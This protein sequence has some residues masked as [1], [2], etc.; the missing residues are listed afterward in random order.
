M[1]ETRSE[2]ERL[3]QEIARRIYIKDPAAWCEQKLGDTLWSGQKKILEAVRKYRK[4]AVQSCH[5]IGK[6][7]ISGRIVAWW[8]DI[9]P[10]GESFVVTSAPTGPQVRT[11]LW[12]EI[13]RAHTKGNLAGRVNQTEWIIRM[14]G[15]NGNPGKEEQVAIG[16]K[17]SDYD[18]AAFQGIHEKRVLYIFDEACGMPL[19]LWEAADSLIAN[20]YSRGLAFGNPD[21]PTTEFCEICKPGSG[22]HV[23][24]IGAFD[25]P[26]FTG[27]DIP[28]DLRERLIGRLY[29]EEKR[30]KWARNWT[31]V[32]K[33]GNPSDADEGVRVVPPPGVDIH[34][35]G[36]FWQSKVLG[37]F[38]IQAEED[39]L[40]PFQWVR[41]AQE[42]TLLPGSENELGIDVGGGGDAS[43]GAHRRGNV[44]RVRWQ[45]RN[46]DTMATTG[47]VVN[48][49]DE[50]SATLAKV[51]L[52]GIGKGVFDRLS[53][54]N[55]PVE[56]INVGEKPD[57][58]KRFVNRRA[59]L[60][61]HLRDLFE[62][63]TIDIDADDEDLASELISVRYKRNSNGKIQIETKIEAQKRNVPSPNRA[64]SIML[65]MA[66]PRPVVRRATWGRR[67][68]H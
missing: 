1:L 65:A 19:N 27:E 12:R 52:V 43:C 56:G 15:K 30:R 34:Q 53:E 20:D 26:N 63:G 2:L 16:R 58:E 35:T 54:L 31:W 10:A 45:D 25:T 22:W 55:R 14:P 48:A 11:I 49:L 68:T 7:F 59:E 42:R 37:E 41:A 64:E 38:P 3:E 33:D 51:D 28:Q 66:P 17:P 57:D 50:T 13:G 29:V 36:A 47:K 24:K 44:V 39:G 4:V 6:S 61:W 62:A 32:D 46:P 23:I 60:W 5:E 40:I 21:D 8:I 18:S 9:H 67:R